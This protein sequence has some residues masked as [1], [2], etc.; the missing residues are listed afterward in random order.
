MMLQRFA[1]DLSDLGNGTGASA[2][3]QADDHVV[4][5][6]AEENKVITIYKIRRMPK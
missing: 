1:S 2:R 3:R 5:T 6:I 4:N